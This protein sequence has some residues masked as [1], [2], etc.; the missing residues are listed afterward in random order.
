MGKASAAVP[1]KRALSAPIRA[2]NHREAFGEDS[3]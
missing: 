1:D 3:E 2:P